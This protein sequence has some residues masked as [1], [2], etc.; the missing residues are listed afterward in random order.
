MLTSLPIH[1]KI[2]RDLTK[3]VEQ[4]LNFIAYRDKFPHQPL[5]AVQRLKIGHIHT[6]ITA[7]LTHSLAWVM[8]RI[9]QNRGEVLEFSPAELVLGGGD[10]CAERQGAELSF[11]PPGLAE[12]DERSHAVYVQI[13]RLSELE[14]KPAK[15]T[16]KKA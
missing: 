12:L 7:R 6:V 3:L 11:L 10:E 8:G 9:A 13:A 16:A 14:T 5:S 15:K 4:S 1:E 2:L